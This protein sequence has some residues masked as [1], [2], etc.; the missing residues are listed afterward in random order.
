MLIA[1][2]LLLLVIANGTPIIAKK[3][4]GHHFDR[5]VDAN[6]RL[7]DGQPLFGATKT[8]RGILLST[9]A[10]GACSSL[11]GLGWHI[12]FVVGVAAMAGDLLASFIKRRLKKPPSSMAPGLDQ[13][14]ESLF[15]LL[16]CKNLLSLS[17][18]DIL[19]LVIVFILVELV[20]SKILYRWHIRAKPY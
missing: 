11:I 16:A 20:L 18:L 14:P 9:V 13:V 5:P 2:L 8:I 19:I 15:P 10:T 17:P 6:V 4:L 3:V 7:F 12:G 1:Q